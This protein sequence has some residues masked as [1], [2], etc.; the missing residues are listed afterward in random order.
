[1]TAPITS[2]ATGGRRVM[3]TIPGRRIILVLFLVFLLLPIYWMVNMSF[4]TNRKSSRP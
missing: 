3:H 4:K 1:M 2:A